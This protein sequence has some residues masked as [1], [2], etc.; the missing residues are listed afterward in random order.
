VG[1]IDGNLRR[2]ITGDLP[3][4]APS[5]F[6]VD[7]QP[8]QIDPFQKR[9]AQTPGVDRVEAAPMLRGLITRINGRPATEVAGEHWVLQGDRGITTS[10]E[11]PPG[12]TITAGE[13]WP[14]DYA[15]PPLVSFAAEAGAE[16]GLELGDTLTLN[17]LGR[18]I[19]A[20][21]ASFREV[22]FESAGLGFILSLDPAALAGAP[23]SWIATIYATEAAE[24]LLLR[25]LATAYPNI[26][27]IRIRDAVA[28]AQRIVEGVAAAVRVAAAAT[29]ATGLL[30]LVGAAAAGER[31]RAWE[32]AILKTLGAE[33][34]LILGSFALRA[35]L[36]GLAAGAVALGAGL[37][38]AWA[39]MRFV[40][41]ADFQV[42][43]GNALSIIFG[44]TLATLLT[45]LAFALG[46]LAL[47]PSRVLRARE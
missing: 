44:G 24:G 13:W 8:D 34:R 9:L 22:N 28:E 26:T 32:A 7:I 45:G 46:P 18:D 15:G 11:P 2:A 42:V 37:L 41:E 38:G 3:A 30:V 36:L 5:Y 20:T 39:V 33:R 31:A 25:D 47:R 6:V 23:Y 4:I 14:P 29:L 1:Q 19:D 10:A 40:M 12:T 17:V 16:L 35:A 27:A 21:I 43:W